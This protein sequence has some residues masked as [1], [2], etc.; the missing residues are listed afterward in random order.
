MRIIA[1]KYKGR[2]LV[3]PRTSGVRPAMDHVKGTIFNVLQNRL[4]LT[5]ASVLDLFAGTGSLGFEAISRGAS[6][7]VFVDDDLT[8]LKTIL[9]TASAFGCADSIQSVSADALSFAGHVEDKF[10]LVFADPPYAYDRTVDIP[11]VIFEHNVLN[12]EGYLIIE[13][14]RRTTLPPSPLYKLVVEKEFGNTRVS[15]IVYPS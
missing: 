3:T 9:T 12:P 5:D 1:G 4:D 15:F 11:R 8:M 13:H 10:D 2:L 6:H 14:S 7:A